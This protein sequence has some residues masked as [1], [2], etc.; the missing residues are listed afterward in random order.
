MTCWV[1][2]GNNGGYGCMKSKERVWC[3]PRPVCNCTKAIANTQRAPFKLKLKTG[4][5]SRRGGRCLTD[6]RGVCVCLCPQRRHTPPHTAIKRACV[7]THTSAICR[8]PNTCNTCNY[9]YKTNSRGSHRNA[10]Q[11]KRRRLVGL[12]LGLLSHLL[13]ERVEKHA[14]NGNTRANHGVLIQLL[15]EDNGRSHDH[16]DTLRSVH[17]R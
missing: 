13:G 6:S 17:D 9:N 11:C 3:S 7:C 16:D 10:A 5:G 1:C 4:H 15:L 2:G 14:Y 12:G 8:R